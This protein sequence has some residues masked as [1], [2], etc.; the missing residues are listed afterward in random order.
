LDKAQKN[1][2]PVESADVVMKEPIEEK[3]SKV[4]GP[5]KI[6]RDQIMDEDADMPE[7]KKVGPTKINLEQEID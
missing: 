5:T 6:S 1:S 7:R 2:V 3:P 4:S